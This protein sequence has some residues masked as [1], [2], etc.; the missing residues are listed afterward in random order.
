MLKLIY[1]LFALMLL[2]TLTGCGGSSVDLP[3]KVFSKD[4]FAVQWIDANKLKPDDAMDLFNGLADDMSD[5]QPKARLWASAQADGIQASYADR[6]EAFTKAGGQG[7]LMVFTAKTQGEGDA[8]RVELDGYILLKVKKGTSSDELRKAL[9]DFAKE[10]GNEK[11]KLDPVDGTDGQWLWLT[12]EDRPEGAS[13]LPGDGSEDNAKSWQDLLK[14]G[15]GAAVVGAWRANDA[16]RDQIKR[17]LDKADDRDLTDE[18]K[19]RL[20]EAQSIESIVMATNGGS[21]ASLAATL[22]FGDK[23]LAKSFAEFHNDRLVAQRMSLKTRLMNS[24]NPPHPSVVDGIYEELVVKASG[25][26]VGLDL[27]SSVMNDGMNIYAATLGQGSVATSRPAQ[28][29]PLHGSLNVPGNLGMGV[30]SC[31]TI[32]FTDR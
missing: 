28:I 14:R 22:E 7:A 17:E 29:F 19:Q 24:E 20:K 23:E 21:S 8:A 26:K 2:V 1:S 15:D 30:P 31:Y 6:W 32:R 12:R 25:K 18:D 27:G 10:D 5:D 4:V 13:K 9:A 11:L 16:I 3:D